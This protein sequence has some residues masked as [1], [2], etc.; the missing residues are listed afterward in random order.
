MHPGSGYMSIPLSH[1]ED[2]PTPSSHCQC[3]WGH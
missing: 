2:T 3:N 1:F